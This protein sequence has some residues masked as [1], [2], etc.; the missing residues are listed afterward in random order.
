MPWQFAQDK[1]DWWCGRFNGGQGLGGLAVDEGAGAAARFDKDGFYFA[2]LQGKKVV[3][4]R[5]VF[6]G[7]LTRIIAFCGG[8]V[9]YCGKEPGT[10]GPKYWE[11]DVAAGVPREHALLNTFGEV[12]LAI[13]E[14]WRRAVMVQTL[15]DRANNRFPQLIKLIREGAAPVDFGRV[16]SEDDLLGAAF[17]GEWTVV[18][19]SQGVQV[20]DG[21][22]IT[23][24]AL[25]RVEKP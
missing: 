8:R 11:Y 23:S 4:T 6:Y 17:S 25:P 24:Y 19:T 21:K 1:E 15:P 3:R 22:K 20:F 5:E 9:L 12:V 2:V 16:E 7:M 18:A 14:D 13:D 10:D